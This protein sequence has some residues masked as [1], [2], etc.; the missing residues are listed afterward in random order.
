[1][2]ANC[3]PPC[4][5]IA[6]ARSRQASQRMTSQEHCDADYASYGWECYRRVAING[7]I[8][9]REESRMYHTF[10]DAMGPVSGGGY[11]TQQTGAIAVAQVKYPAKSAEFSGVW[12]K[13]FSSQ[14][15]ICRRVGERFDNHSFAQMHVLADFLITEEKGIYPFKKVAQG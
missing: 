6:L 7:A 8:E 11:R 9:D 10:I 3:T 1:M 4:Q 12:Y 14:E 2:I 13:K 15:D 5:E